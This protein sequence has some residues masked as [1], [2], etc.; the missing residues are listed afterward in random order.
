MLQYQS[1]DLHRGF[2]FTWQWSVIDWRRKCQV[3]RGALYNIASSKILQECNKTPYGISNRTI[4]P[5]KIRTKLLTNFNVTECLNP[6]SSVR[7][8]IKETIEIFYLVDFKICFS[9]APHTL[10]FWGITIV[11]STFIV[12]GPYSST[13][14]QNISTSSFI[15]PQSSAFSCSQFARLKKASLLNPS[16]YN[17]N[18][19]WRHVCSVCMRDR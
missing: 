15:F 7:L 12:D 9:L 8:E 3:W 6:P 13:W 4:W 17:I 14:I 11:L 5:H 2:M 10:Q 16:S 1:P 18:F 19:C